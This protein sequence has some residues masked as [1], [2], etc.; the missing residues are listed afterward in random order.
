M[1]LLT[2]DVDMVIFLRSHGSHGAVRYALTLELAR[3]CV[4]PSTTSSQLEAKDDMMS[5]G[6]PIWLVVDY[7]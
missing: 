5:V 2:P 7:G 4:S 3:S 6:K 1:F